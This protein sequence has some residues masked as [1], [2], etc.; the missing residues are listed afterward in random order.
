MFNNQIT[1]KYVISISDKY[2]ESIYGTAWQDESTYDQV[3]K[4]KLM[5]EKYDEIDMWLTGEENS[6]KTLSSGSYYDPLTQKEVPYITI[7]VIDDK[8]KDGKHL[9][10]SAAA[11]SEILFALMMNPALIGAGQPGGPYSNNAGGSNIR[12]SYLTQMMISEAER[13]DIANVLTLVKNYNGWAKR[14]ENSRTVVSGIGSL[15]TKREFTPRLVF[16]CVSNFMTTLDTG[17]NT[18]NTT[19]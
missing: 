7:T 5:E 6:Y 18:K 14:L 8:V 2:W 12:E 17:K 9:P 11:N 19:M 15:A 3:Q 10:E 1:L 4:K 13:K 16:R